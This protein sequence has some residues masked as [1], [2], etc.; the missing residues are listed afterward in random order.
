MGRTALTV[1]SSHHADVTL[2]PEACQGLQARPTKLS[3]G[4]AVR[5]GAF[6]LGSDSWACRLPWFARQQRGEGH[7]EEDEAAGRVLKRGQT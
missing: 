6:S 1:G 4:S 2:P 3:R 5:K 7:S